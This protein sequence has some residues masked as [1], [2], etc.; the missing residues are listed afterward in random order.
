MSIKEFSLRE[1]ADVRKL[2]LGT[3]V[4]VRHLAEP[5]YVQVL[6]REF[7]QV[8]A[9]N[10]MKFE[11]LH[12]RPNTDPTPYDFEA[13]DQLVA[14]AKAHK[15]EVRGHCLVWHSQVAQWLHD[16]EKTPSSLSQILQD[17]IKTVV[18][19]YAGKLNAWDVVNE[20]F[21][22][23][24]SLR[25]SLW[26]DEPGIGLADAD[27]GYI[28]AA[29]RWTH[30]TDSSAKLYYNDYDADEINPKSDAIYAMAAHFLK[31][32]VPIHGVGFQMHLGLDSDTPDKLGSIRDNLH[33]F[34]ELGLDV[35]VTECDIRLPDDSS[36]SL[37][38]Q[39]D[40]YKKI[41][42]IC[43]AE[44]RCTSVQLWGFT[45]KYSWI[46]GFTA[47]KAGWALIFDNQYEPKP[48]YVAI[49]DSLRGS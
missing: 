35:Q 37:R 43:L 29:F 26:F 18:G 15:M 16:S 12:P 21:E 30:E 44:P 39:A 42:D 5:E 38:K 27:T 47:G 31:R 36:E 19:H 6:S 7:N 3:A 10:E 41:F 2:L 25:H 22:D 48:A 28:E 24:G 1:L 40:L 11:S 9:E 4:T 33:R 23:D 8:E 13:A 45:D 46:P 32:E 34:A 17:H 20:A 14:F 49:R